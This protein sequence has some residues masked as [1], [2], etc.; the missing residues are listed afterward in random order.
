[1]LLNTPRSEIIGMVNLW[2]YK[3]GN[4]ASEYLRV[5]DCDEGFK[6]GVVDYINPENELVTK[7]DNRSESEAKKIKQRILEAVK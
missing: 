1:M 6:V 7:E 2:T 5:I 3:T 4:R